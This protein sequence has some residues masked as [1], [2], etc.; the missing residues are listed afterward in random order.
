MPFIVEAPI[1]EGEIK[2]R[3]PQITLGKG[4]YAYL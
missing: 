4:L 1:L 3:V 2:R